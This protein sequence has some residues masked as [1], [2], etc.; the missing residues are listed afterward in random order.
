MA[1]AF[2]AHRLDITMMHRR[3]TQVVV[4]LMTPLARDPDVPA[5][6]ARQRVWMRPTASTHLD[7]DAL[8][9]LHLVAITWWIRCR[10]ASHGSERE[11]G[12]DLA[13]GLQD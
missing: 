2:S 3:V 9:R 11:K 8:A 10:A 13:H 6:S 12:F 4:V 5:I 1:L 7:I